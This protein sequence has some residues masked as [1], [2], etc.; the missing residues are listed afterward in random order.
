MY[1]PFLRLSG[2]GPFEERPDEGDV[3]RK[4]I[5]EHGVAFL[6]Q[7]NFD[8]TAVAF[9]GVTSNR[10]PLPTSRSR[11]PV[12]VPLV[13][14]VWAESSEQ[15]NPSVSPN[16]AMMSNC[17]GVKPQGTDMTPIDQLE[18]QIG[19][20]ERPQYFQIG[21]ILEIRYFHAERIVRTRTNGQGGGEAAGRLLL[22]ERA[23]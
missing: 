3:C 4:G 8:A 1:G 13:T 22:A 21:I 16:V 20:D 12:N 6:G 19:L 23:R 2:S 5:A 10:A 11:T 14:R 15:V 9:H 18:G 7:S 17:E